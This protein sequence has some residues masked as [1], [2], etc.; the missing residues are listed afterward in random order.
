[1][2]ATGGN[3]VYHQ[4]TVRILGGLRDEIKAK[5]AE[6]G[7]QTMVYYPIPVHKLPTY[8]NSNVTLTKTEKAAQEVLSLPIWPHITEAQQSRVADTLRAALR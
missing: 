3:H 1:V 5:L 6:A 2:D 8:A 7:I 4:Y